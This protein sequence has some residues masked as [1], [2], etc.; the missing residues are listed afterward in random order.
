MSCSSTLL[1]CPDVQLELS[2]YFQTCN[3]A[4]LGRE[5]SFLS[6]LTSMENMTGINQVVNPGGAKTR[7]VI[8]RYDSGIPVANVQEVTECNLDCAAENQGGD[9]SAEYSMD[10]CQKIKYGES[11]NVYDLANIC[12]SNQDFIAARLNA[13]AGAIEQKIAQ[14]TA[15][16]AVALVGGWAS[17]VSNVTGAVKQVATK[18]SAGGLN[19]YFMPEI[20]LA[21]KQNGYC[22]PIGIFG[23]S[24]LYLSTDLLNVGCCATEGVDLL[25]VMGRYGKAV[26]WDSYVVDAFSSNNISLMTQ[27]G[28]MQLLTYTIGTEASFNPLASG[29][30]SNFEIIP[31]VTPRYGIPVDLIVSN[32]CGQISLTMQVSTKLVALPLDLICSGASAGVNFVNLLEVNNA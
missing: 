15:E 27:L 14:K 28:A 19:P 21:A 6:M 11:Y 31:L 24:E 1:N 29:A 22:A 10:I 7:T 25:G 30:A 13:M 26:A 32:S 12:R 3:V 4:V 5:S 20:D 23:G 18:T 8:L 17:D 16:E 2:S 9:N